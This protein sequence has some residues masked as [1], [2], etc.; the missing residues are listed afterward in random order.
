MLFHQFGPASA[1]VVVIAGV[2]IWATGIAW[3]DPLVSLVIVA[4]IFIQTWG[5]LRETV[6]MSLAAVPRGN[7][8]G[9]DSAGSSGANA[10]VGYSFA[11]SYRAPRL[12]VPD[13]SSR[14][15]TSSSPF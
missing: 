13:G 11:Y 1:V 14:T 9:M 10:V 7:T 3:I 4:V 5:L 2:A 12:P 6:E 15:H 8:T